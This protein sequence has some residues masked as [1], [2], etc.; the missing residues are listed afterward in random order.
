MLMRD[1]LTTFLDTL[2]LLLVAAGIAAALYQWI[3]WA[4]L[5]PAG[6]LVLGGSALASWQS[7]PP[8]TPG[9]GV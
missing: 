5:A 6:M 4:S 2:G 7:R 3:G 9:D 1:V 8:E